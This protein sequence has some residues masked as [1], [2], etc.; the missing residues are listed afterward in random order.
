MFSFFKRKQKPEPKIIKESLFERI[1]GG[2]QLQT[3]SKSDDDFLNPISPLSPLNPLNTGSYSANDAPSNQT[4][5]QATDFGGGDFGG[6]GA[7]GSWNSDVPIHHGSDPD[8]SSYDSGSSYDSSSDSS[9]Y[10]SGSSY[11]SSSSDSSSSSSF[12]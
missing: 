4:N 5:V 12:D 1:G 9:S 2:Y 7:G 8:V 6:G 11:D 3:E 10:D